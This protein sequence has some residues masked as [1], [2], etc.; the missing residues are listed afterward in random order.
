MV[1]HVLAGEAPNYEE[2]LV[3]RVARA[4]GLQRVGYLV[5]EAIVA[6]IDTS[7]TRTDD[8]RPVLWPPGEEPRVSFPH[9]AADPGVRGHADTPMAEL[10]GLAGTLQS[11]ASEADGTEARAVPHRSFRA[12]AVR[13]RQR[14]GASGNPFVRR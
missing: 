10:V 13:T 11:N 9:R 1:A 7:V 8:G 5:R 6:Q 14:D 12:G 2:L 3:R 4:H